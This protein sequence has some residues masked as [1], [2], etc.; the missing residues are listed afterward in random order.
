[1]SELLNLS[2][3]T[4]KVPT[5]GRRPLVLSTWVSTVSTV[6]TV[7]TPVSAVWLAIVPKLPRHMHACPM[8]PFCFNKKSLKL[9]IQKSIRMLQKSENTDSD[10]TQSTV[11]CRSVGADRWGRVEGL[12]TAEKGRWRRTHGARFISRK[13]LSWNINF[14]LKKFKTFGLPGSQKSMYVIHIMI[15]AIWGESRRAG[16]K[17]INMCEVRA[18]GSA[19]LILYEIRAPTIPMII[20]M[21]EYEIR[22]RVI[23]FVITRK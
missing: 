5:A 15:F 3:P 8:H 18:P 16:P 10:L 1:M 12:R 7:V 21:Y 23:F 9:Y 14:F 6:S 19:F 22:A 13:N 4:S 2:K 17:C 20:K 11:G